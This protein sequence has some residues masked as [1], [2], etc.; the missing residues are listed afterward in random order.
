MTK[1]SKFI[2]LAACLLL[3]ISCFLPWTYHDDVGKFFTGFFSEKDFYGKPGKFLGVFAIISALLI[4]VP[5]IWAKR[6]NMF[7]AAILMGYAI[8]VYIL[9]TSCYN[10][11]CPDKQPGIFMMMGA[12]ILIFYARTVPEH[13]GDQSTPPAK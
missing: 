9:Y 6:T 12:C 2:G 8:R 11:Y 5:R 10:A 1:Y 13:E 4:L 3:I 7:V